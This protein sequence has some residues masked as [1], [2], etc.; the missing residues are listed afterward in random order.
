[1]A[2]LADGGTGA[3]SSAQ[4]RERRFF[5]GMAIAI[6]AFVVTGFGAYAILGI[7]SFGAPWWVH[8]HA[9]TYMGWIALYLNQNLLVVRGDLARHRRMGQLMAL[10]AVWMVVVG[11]SL[12]LFNVATH[13]VPPIFTP[14]FMLAMNGLTLLGFVVLLAAGLRMRQHSDW[15]KRLMLSATVCVMAP[16]LGRI[17]V[18]STGFSMRNILLMQLGFV[19]AGMLGDWRIHGRIHPAYYWGAAV[20]VLAGLLPAPLSTFAPLAS[21]AQTLAGG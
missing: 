3:P 15:H 17:T 18:V 12:Q 8:V 2:T 14:V 7:S 19:A 16:A 4:Q 6:A 11:L 9:L 5:L 1:M 10:W 13:K 20:L 21:F